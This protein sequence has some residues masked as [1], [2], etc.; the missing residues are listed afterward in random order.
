MRLEFNVKKIRV[1]AAMPTLA[2]MTDVMEAIRA[3]GGEVTHQNMRDFCAA[4]VPTDTYDKLVE[5]VPGCFF[6]L[7]QE[8]L[9]ELGL[10]AHVK[11][12]KEEELEGDMAAAYVENEKRIPQK[13]LEDPEDERGKLYPMVFNPYDGAGQSTVDRFAI[14]RYPYENEIDV[15]RKFRTYEAR[16]T[17]LKKCCVWGDMDCLETQAPCLYGTLSETLI[18]IAGD[19][20]VTRVGK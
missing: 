2:Q 11:L 8:I 1:V 15:V 6:D 5:R 16:K 4:V 17:F 18:D 14:F 10:V 13:F 12:L 3:S 20:A 7:G 9:R 19:G